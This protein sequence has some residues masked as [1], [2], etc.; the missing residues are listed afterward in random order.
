MIRF[1]AGALLIGLLL[2]A[3]VQAKPRAASFEPA[4]LSIVAKDGRERSI[5]V[6]S[7]QQLRNAIAPCSGK[8]RCE[9]ISIETCDRC[10]LSAD[11]VRGGYLIQSRL[12]PPGPLYDLIDDRA[13]RQNTATFSLKD[14]TTI[15]V[16]YLTDRK[17]IP[18]ARRDTGQI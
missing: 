17:T 5:T 1:I 2:P 15:F 7:A 13:G 10:Y 12:G 11:A 16:D 9:H 4:T 8:T 6:R 18:L 3:S 14:L